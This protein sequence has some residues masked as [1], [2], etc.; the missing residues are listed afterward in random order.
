MTSR[1]VLALAFAIS[2]YCTLRVL[3][4]ANAL[5]EADDVLD[6]GIFDSE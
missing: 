1:I 2:I 5:V 3:T 4:F 6:L